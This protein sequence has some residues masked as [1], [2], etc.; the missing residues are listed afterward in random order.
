MNEK[1]PPAD[2]NGRWVR[3]VVD[4]LGLAAFLVTLM[5]TGSAIQASWAVVGG[6]IAALIV[7][8]VFEKRIAPLPLATAVV[9]AIFGAATIYFHDERI[10]KMKL[11]ILDTGIGIALLTALARG[12]N[13]LRALIGDELHLPD[14]VVRTLTIRYALMFF[15]LAAANEVIWRTQTTRIW[16]LYKFPGTAVI[17][18]LFFLSQMPLIMKH[19][20]KDEP[21]AK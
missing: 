19:A 2:K 4:Y 11:T 17:I 9:G 6:S 8:L 18:F 5:V 14:A 20:P 13:P 16:G 10:I 15:V 21:A 7:G 1:S 3:L 12:K